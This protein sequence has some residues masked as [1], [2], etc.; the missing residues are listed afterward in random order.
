MGV[1]FSVGTGGMPVLASSRGAER[2]W[3]LHESPKLTL[4]LGTV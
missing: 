3:T 4:H 2:L 1:E